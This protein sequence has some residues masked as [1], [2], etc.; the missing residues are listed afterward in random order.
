MN[1]P[2]PHSFDMTPS[3]LFKDALDAIAAGTRRVK[4]SGL[5]GS[6]EAVF[7][8]HLAGGGYSFCAVAS[9]QPAAERL[10][11]DL[12]LFFQ[13]QG[14][15]RALLFFPPWDV[16]AYEPTAPRADR[17]GAR[18]SV[19]HHLAQDDRPCVVTSIDAVLQ[20]VIAPSLLLKEALLIQQGQRLGRE[21]LVESLDAQGYRMVDLVAEPGDAAVRGGI[22]DF[23]SPALPHPVRVEFFGEVI[24][25]LRAFDPESQRS[26]SELTSVEIIHGR[27]AADAPDQVP[28][29][30][31][32]SP[33]ALWVIDEPTAVQN[34]AE[35]FER[36]V[37]DGKLFAAR[38]D[39]P[40]PDLY[41]SL[42]DLNAAAARYVTIEMEH[43]VL[44]NAPGV[45]RCVYDSRTIPSIGFGRPGQPVA[46]ALER[47]RL[48]SRD[49]AVQVVVRHESRIDHL[50]RLFTDHH[51][52]W[53]PWTAGTAAPARS[54]QIVVG[55]LSA[56][57]TLPH[58]KWI[59]LTEEE[60][61]GRIAAR[62]HRR[63]RGV[64][65]VLISSIHD[66]KP[67]DF[68]VHIHHGIGRY[69][70]L[71]QIA[72]RQRETETGQ[73]AD[74][75]VIEYA[76]GDKVYVPMDALHLVQRY[77]GSAAAPAALDRLG[78]TRWAKAKA[79]AKRQIDEMMEPLLKLYAE[80]QVIQGNSFSA[81]ETA[82]DDFAAAF[83]YEPTP[84]QARS[85]EEVLADMQRERP[86]DRLVCGDVGF[87]KTEVA[88]RAAFCAVMDHR[89]VAIIA[90]TTLLA[91]Q[92][93]HTFTKRFTPFGARVEVLSRF[94][95]AAEQKAV[96]ADARA[97]TVDILIGTHRLLQKDVVYR[98]LGLV[99]I[100][101]EHR[102]GVRHKEW[103]KT[104]R[105]TVDVLTL[106]ATPIP[107]T[108]QMAV[109]Q[110]RDLSVIETAPADRL[111]IQTTIA[112]FDP[113]IIR[114]AVFRELVRGG[115]V[116]FVH[117]RVHNIEVLG[118]YLA[119]LIPEAKIG[120]AHGQ[121][122]EQMLEEVILK[123]VEK[124]YTLLLTTTIIE[125]GIDI[126]SANTI[127]INNADHF[128][129]AELYQLR[130][131][132]GR[133]GEQSYAYLLV[134]EE[135]ILSDDA[136]QRL[137][138]IQEFTDLGSGFQ[139]A[140]R[141]LEIRGAGN[142]LGGEQSGHVAAVGFDLY[143]KMIQEKVGELR[144]TAA[145]PPPMLTIQFQAPAYLPDTYVSE[146]WQRL[147]LYKRISDLRS[148]EEVEQMAA[149]MGDRF[150]PPPEEAARLL[151]LMRIR[152]MAQ[153]AQVLKIVQ[154]D[155]ALTFVVD[156]TSQTA[157]CDPEPLTRQFRRRIRFISSAAFEIDLTAADWKTIYS[158]IVRVLTTLVPAETAAG[159]IKNAV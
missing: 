130:G 88:M 152:Q 41:L 153:S 133:C 1:P 107:R 109:A 102:F 71:R 10:H 156:P 101:E 100:D 19:L 52:S 139:V 38:R 40:R 39:Q 26:L 132:V 78:G 105:S 97:G 99:V 45:R 66:V 46:E 70:G 16:L 129:L 137:R 94:R 27:E 148:L 89:Q 151:D 64:A 98:D 158:E 51:I 83:E 119:E 47:L 67:G 108:L 116:F 154:K 57:F 48:L 18:L 117:D 92:H 124:E 84:D 44:T 73:S 15:D 80:R 85:I 126:P 103:L 6:A 146:A 60:L 42:D 150:G 53:T 55:D 123:F 5:E 28:F 149:E 87:G 77:V 74:F 17:V 140:A 13:T 58:E 157:S 121:M 62:L 12:S 91:H 37:E 29:L 21:A 36:R 95:T 125:S 54:V 8:A 34:E 135:R 31:Y 145:A 2:G 35:R 24:E 122:R 20:K 144:G 138:A 159:K 115:Q 72:V 81:N 49:H 142:L 59:V 11:A 134:Q 114:E 104:L 106:T 128:G 68:V 90:P 65:G 30:T 9:S 131:R 155:D 110:V 33:S 141:D 22:V 111:P 69:V 82:M 79:Q 63:S 4:V 61:T 14:I 120:I 136:R 96:V 113:V 56:G 43:L 3:T 147:T 112:P 75:F 86:M 25:S 127:L 76:G 118:R 7:L 23:F 143:M 93:Y 50:G 32:L